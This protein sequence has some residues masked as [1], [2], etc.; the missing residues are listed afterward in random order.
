MKKIL[1]LLLL[2]ATSL[3]LCACSGQKEVADMPYTASISGTEYSGSF[4]GT[5]LKKLP[6]GEGTFSYANH[7]I[8][9]SYSGQWEAGAPVGVGILEFDGLVVE[10]NGNSYTGVYSGEAVAGVPNGNGSFTF[11]SDGGYLKYSGFWADG[12]FSGEGY[13]ETDS[14]ILHFSD[15][16][17][18][19]GEYKG[20]TVDGEASGTGTFAAVN[21]EGVSYTYT[22]EWKNGIMN[23]YGVKKFDDPNYRTEKGNF[24]NGNF[25]PTPLEYFSALGSPEYHLFRITDNASSFIEKYADVF[26]NNTIEGTDIEIDNNFTYK[27]FAKNPAKHGDKLIKIHGLYVV[28]IIEESRWGY[29]LTFCIVEDSSYNVYSVYMLGCAEDIYK[30]SY[31]T[32]TAL[33]LDYFTYK[34][35]SGNNIWAM[36]CAAVSIE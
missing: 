4:S 3:S 23:G 20:D 26:V 18:R 34:G 13:L 29:D 22:G 32:L 21:D 31:I 14:Y 5:V 1:A 25:A 27:S 28:Q 24:E 19:Q 9:L 17:A 10:Y 7:H 8:S 16:T 33:P 15:G 11:L 6:Q 36:A 30:G 12:V 2:L 35:V